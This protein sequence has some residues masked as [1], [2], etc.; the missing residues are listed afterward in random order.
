MSTISKYIVGEFFKVFLV[1]LTVLTLFVLLFGVAREALLQ[2]LGP[3]QVARLIPY[4][5]P[6]ALQLT[7][8][9]TTLFATCSIY[10][11]L[12]ASNEIVALK[13][14]GISPLSVLRPMLCVVFLMSMG[15]VVL[16][17]IATSWGRSGVQRVIIESVEEIAYGMLRTKRS[18]STSRF[19]ITVKNVEG[20]TLILPTVTFQGSGDK[21]SV[22]ITAQKASLQTSLEEG[23]LKIQF[24]DGIVEVGNTVK[25]H[26]PGVEEYI[27][28]LSDASRKGG[29]AMNPSGIP[30]SE[31]SR[32]YAEQ[33][34]QLD[35][36]QQQQAAE[37]AYGMMTGNFAALSNE[38]WQKSHREMTSAQGRLHRLSVEKHRRWSDGL[39]CLCFA[40]VGAP[41]AIRLR[42]ADLLKS[43]FACFM[44]ILIAYY[45]LL[46][47]SLDR[48]KAGEWPASAMWLANG[49]LVLWGLWLTRRVM[50][51]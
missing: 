49:M 32:A 5:L 20:T 25:A 44:P 19:A 17:D 42:N 22:T 12:A 48:T 33:T 15:C 39:V 24:H 14:L 13:S 26:F 6:Q 38:S 34:T 23:T 2:G 29:R 41:M 36:M 43:F 30:L 7:I 11:R 3:V 27:V 9:G 45:P 28:P 47:I 50:R 35:E 18:Y 16:N 4:V 1:A 51:Y 46:A 40:M 31:L 21:P 37:A 10:G 8:P